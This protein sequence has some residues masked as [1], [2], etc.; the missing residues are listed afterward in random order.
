MEKVALKELAEEARQILSSIAYEESML[1]NY[2]ALREECVVR[3]RKWWCRYGEIL[4]KI[5]LEFVSDKKYG[6]YLEREAIDVQTTATRANAIWLANNMDKVTLTAPVTVTHP[7]SLRD[8]WRNSPL[9]P[10]KPFRRLKTESEKNIEKKIQYHTKEGKKMFQD[11]MAKKHAQYAGPPKDLGPRPSI[12]SPEEQAIDYLLR[13]GAPNMELQDVYLLL[14]V[15][16]PCRASTMKDLIWVAMRR[17]HPDK[18]GSVE[19]AA[20]YT[21]AKEIINN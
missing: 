2:D 19:I 15:S 1:K 6:Q 16:G 10:P 4:Q 13:K 8:A 20:L 14:G 11:M 7:T 18:G 9:A 3:L 12:V 21:R 17:H 5:R